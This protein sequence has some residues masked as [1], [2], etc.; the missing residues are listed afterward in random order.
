[1]NF[2]P[3]CYKKFLILQKMVL[4]AESLRMILTEENRPEI[5]LSQKYF[6]SQITRL[7]NKG[8]QTIV[9]RVAANESPLPAAS[10]KTPNSVEEPKSKRCLDVDINQHQHNQGQGSL[11]FNTIINTSNSISPE[12]VPSSQH[13]ILPLERRVKRYDE[14]VRKIDGDLQ[15]KKSELK[16]LDGKLSTA[17]IQ[18]SGHLSACGNCHL[19]LGHTRK[20]CKFSPRK[21]AFS[22]GI[23]SKHADQK[24]CRAN[25][26]RDVNKLES[27]LRKATNDLESA[28]TAAER[29]N[30]SSDKR[31]ADILMNQEPQRYMTSCGRRNWLMLNKDVA[32]LQSNLKGTLPTRANIM[33]LLHTVARNKESRCALSSSLTWRDTDHRMAAQK[34]VLEEEYSIKFPTKRLSEASNEVSDSPSC[35]RFLYGQEK[36]DFHLALKLQQQEIESSNSTDCDLY[37]EIPASEKQDEVEDPVPKIIETDD[38]LQF[39]ANAAAALLHLKKRK[40]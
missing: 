14:V 23:I 27:Q 8:L 1:M 26:T 12:C 22:C 33:N 28:R 30:N 20:A 17:S 19:K 21:S 24:S 37:K 39:E 10:R 25:I 5:D 29:V 34:R 4:P 36:N 16:E 7:L 13:V 3:E 9:I 35:S 2:I 11:N 38:E 15:Q 32:L 18:N 31:I 6:K 40:K